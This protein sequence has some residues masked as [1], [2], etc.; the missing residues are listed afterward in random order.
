MF[1]ELR[2]HLLPR[3]VRQPRGWR[4]A[5][6]QTPG[7]W[8]GSDFYDFLSL[9]DGRL[10]LVL[11]G[12]SDQGAPA[13]ALAAMVRVVLHS[14]P[15]SSGRERMPYCPLQEPVLQPPH[16]LLGHLNQV[17]AEN[18]L[19]EQYLTAFCGLIG[20]GSGTLLYA[21]AGH[22]WPRVWRAAARAVEPVSGQADLPL[23]LHHT[24]TYRKRRLELD[25]GDLFLLAS[26][27]VIA[28]RSPWDEAFGAG[29]LDDALAAVAADGPDAV[30]ETTMNEL[31]Q[32]VGRRR[33]SGDLTLVAVQRVSDAEPDSGSASVRRARDE[34]Q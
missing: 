27:E 9:P 22:P 23:G 33:P 14:C 34:N 11:T 2:R 24:T 12:G 8:K 13:T 20:P 26:E 1:R 6:R 19:E 31:T 3:D 30:V 32:F 16:I 7:A 29:A 21:N 18:S 15:L 4:L 28:A 17:L 5:V 10:L 25:P